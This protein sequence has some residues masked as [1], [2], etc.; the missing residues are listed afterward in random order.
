MMKE[1]QHRENR[2]K[3]YERQR[4]LLQRYPSHSMALFSVEDYFY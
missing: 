2:R 3:D 4:Y 1:E